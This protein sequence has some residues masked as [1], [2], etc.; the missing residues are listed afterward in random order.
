LVRARLSLLLLLSTVL[1]D[2]RILSFILAV[3]ATS[4]NQRGAYQKKKSQS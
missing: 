4:E 1:F 3:A 2:R